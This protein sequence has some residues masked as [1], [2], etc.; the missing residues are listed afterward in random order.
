MN[1]GQICPKYLED[2]YSIILD[3]LTNF[4]VD[5]TIISQIITN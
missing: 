4:H 5:P 1:I 2:G 3:I